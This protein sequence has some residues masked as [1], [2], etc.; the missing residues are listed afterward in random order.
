MFPLVQ[1]YTDRLYEDIEFAVV[2]EVNKERFMRGEPYTPYAQLTSGVNVT[3]FFGFARVPGMKE[4]LY[5]CMS[6]N[7]RISSVHVNFQF[8]TFQ[9][10][11]EYQ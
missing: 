1:E 10:E 7:N 4:T 2:D 6:N 8:Q 11:Q 3:S 5:L 9:I